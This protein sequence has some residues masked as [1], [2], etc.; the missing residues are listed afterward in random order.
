MSEKDQSNAKDLFTRCE[1]TLERMRIRREDT[2]R[3]EMTE[4][5]SRLRRVA[6]ER[7]VLEATTMK[8]PPSPPPS[9]KED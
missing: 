5:L 9:S 2:V 1:E 7:R 4:R 8:S 3:L 6:H